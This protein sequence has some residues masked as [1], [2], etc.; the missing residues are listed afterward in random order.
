MINYLIIFVHILLILSQT[1]YGYCIKKNN[2]DHIY[3]VYVYFLLLHWIFLKGECIISYLYKKLQKNDYELGSNSI[4]DDLHYIVGDYK[5]YIIFVLNI[6]FMISVFIVSKRNNIKTHYILIF[7]LYYYVYI[8]F[9]YY[10]RYHNININTNTNFQL[11]NDI[12]KILLIFFGIYFY[13]NNRTFF[14]K[15]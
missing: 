14:I 10:I 13:R 1:L 6:I 12:I 7:I 5:L 2:Y 4:N 3:L 8:L 15:Q 11:F 9:L